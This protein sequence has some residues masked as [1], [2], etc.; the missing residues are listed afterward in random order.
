MAM[1]EPGFGPLGDDSTDDLP[2]TFRREKEARAREAR[3]R[4]AQERASAPPSLSAPPKDMASGPAPQIYAS[5]D[6][7]PAIADMPFPA[8]VRRFD[9]PFMH[10]VTFFLKAV[11]AAIPALILLMVIMW[12]LGQGMQVL[13]PDLAKMKI[14]IGFGG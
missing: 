4:A 9:V 11:V 7:Q 1:A 5:A 6:V 3:E 2:R 10:L 13:F 8:A 14:L 12:A